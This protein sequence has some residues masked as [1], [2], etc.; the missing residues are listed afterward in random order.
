MAYE[1]L[2]A[3]NVTDPSEYRRYR[4][5]MLPILARYGGGFRYDFVV[6]QTLSPQPE[7]PVTRLFAIFFEDEAASRAFF[8]DESY[9]AVR[10]RHYVGA[11][12]GRT[13]VA[14]YTTS[15]GPG[16]SP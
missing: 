16:E 6:S 1:M 14:A 11:V 10:Q 15:D 8:A 13:L 2:V 12:D 7:H 4:E 3:M 9:Q 5:G